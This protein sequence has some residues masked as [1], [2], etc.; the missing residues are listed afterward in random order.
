MHVSPAF[1]DDPVAAG[2]VR[3]AEVTA[4]AASA[5]CDGHLRVLRRHSLQE[6]QRGDCRWRGEVDQ[7]RGFGQLEY[8]SPPVHPDPGGLRAAVDAVP[9]LRVPTEAEA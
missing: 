7:L 9:S 1:R 4:A 3:L 5:G 6:P 8:P 2:P